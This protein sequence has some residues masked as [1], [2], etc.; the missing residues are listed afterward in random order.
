MSSQLLQQLEDKIDS[1]IEIIELLHIQIEEL[2]EK[3]R[4]LHADNAALKNR[5]TQWEQNLASLLRK[6][7]GADLSPINLETSKMERFE[8]EKEEAIA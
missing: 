8:D 6:L 2:E 1:A 7:E 4:A 3:N 5:Q